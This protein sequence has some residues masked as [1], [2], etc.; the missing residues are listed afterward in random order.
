[1][2]LQRWKPPAW[3]E[4]VH[5]AD[6]VINIL[7]SARSRTGGDDHDARRSAVITRL[8]RRSQTTETSDATLRC[9]HPQCPLHVDTRHSIAC[10]SGGETCVSRRRIARHWRR[11]L[12]E[13]FADPSR[14]RRLTRGSARL[15]RFRPALV[16]KS[17]A[18]Q[19]LGR[20]AI[21][22]GLLR[23]AGGKLG[24]GPAWSIEC[25]PLLEEH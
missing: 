22:K 25:L 6:V 8:P 19:D 11:R 13:L 23:Y 9:P 16:M 3:S 12:A 15:F 24:P 17:T 10:E 2:G 7:A 21:V 20:K 14:E 4:G 1:M 5:S 18:S